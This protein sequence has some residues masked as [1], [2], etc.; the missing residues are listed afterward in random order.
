MEIAYL[1]DHAAHIPELARLHFVA[2]E[3]EDLLG[4]ALLVAQDLESR[5]HLTPWLAGI[6]VKPQH[7]GKRIGTRLIQRIEAEARSLGTDVL[8]LYTSTTQ[9]LYERLGWS[10]M[11]RCD[12]QGTEVVVMSKTLV[13]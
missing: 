10:V 5:P 13:L 3:G 2:L 11:E 1:I 6:F 4:S 7:R 8:Y 9:S 12:D